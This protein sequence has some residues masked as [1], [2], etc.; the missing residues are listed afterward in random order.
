M[1]QRRTLFLV[2]FTV[3]LDLLG[4]GILIPLLPYVAVDYGATSFEVGLLMA[5]YSLAQFIFSPI[6]GRLSD[7]IGRRPIMILSLVGSVVGYLMFA[8]SHT[9]AWLF[10]SRLLSG[11]AAANIST[12]N[13]I[14]A[15]VMP[16][17]KRTKGMGLVGAAIGLGFVFGPALAGLFVGKDDYMLPFLIAAGLSALDLV[18]VI[19]FLPETRKVTGADVPGR[20]R[21][22]IKLL[23][24]AMQA[25]FIPSLLIISLCY[26]TAFSAMESTF[27]LFVFS[28]YGWS[29]RTNGL[30]LF[31]VGLVL[32][33]VQGG[34]VGRVAKWLGDFNVLTYGL[35]GLT[36][37]LFLMCLSY[38]PT[39][40]LP[41]VFILSVSAGFATPSM[42]SLISQLS[43][44]DF[45]G[46]ML[47]MQQS[48]A[49]MGRIIGP[50][51]GTFAFGALGHHSPFAISA[52]IVLAAFLLMLPMRFRGA[53]A[54]VRPANLAQP[55]EAE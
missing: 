7:R 34:L 15:D 17:E 28:E 22:S 6:W 43:A 18:L 8:F 23:R 33:F 48:M 31:C 3:F 16:P 26:Y 1:N 53:T 32:A 38:S 45:Q 29:A 20:R 24:D 19:F 44:D 40:F 25:P 30:V 41:A 55:E 50:L 4:F 10:V 47:G 12:A 35:A 13:A 5:I 37:G 21:F 46:G 27:A 51:L 36:V 14:V 52:V 39:L 2:F 54:L 11:I 49:S 9:L 42:T